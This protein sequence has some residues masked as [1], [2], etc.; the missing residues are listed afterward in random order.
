MNQPTGFLVGFNT[1]AR[2]LL[3]ADERVD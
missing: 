2:S 1:F 3:V